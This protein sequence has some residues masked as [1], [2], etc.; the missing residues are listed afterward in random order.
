MVAE[1]NEILDQGVLENLSS[2][3]FSVEKTLN[4]I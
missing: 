1:E 4:V 3:I 2:L